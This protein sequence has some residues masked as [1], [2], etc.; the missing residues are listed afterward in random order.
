MGELLKLGNIIFLTP[1][2]FVGSLFLKIEGWQPNVA[3]Y[4]VDGIH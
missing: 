4:E 1:I 3:L 2:P